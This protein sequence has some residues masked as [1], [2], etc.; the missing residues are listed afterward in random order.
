MLPATGILLGEIIGGC[1]PR[2]Q[3]GKGIEIYK[4]RNAD[5]AF[6]M[7]QLLGIHIYIK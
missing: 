7:T 2:K 5:I 1:A 3:W 4:K 6:Y